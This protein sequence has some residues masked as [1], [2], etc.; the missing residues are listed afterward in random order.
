MTTICCTINF[1]IVDFYIAPLHC[2]YVFVRPHV[3]H[4]Y[5]TSLERTVLLGCFKS[6]A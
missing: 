4:T 5:T 2:M 1:Y 3:S 6:R